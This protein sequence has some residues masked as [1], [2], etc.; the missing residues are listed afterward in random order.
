MTKPRLHGRTEIDLGNVLEARRHI[1][2]LAILQLLA[3]RPFALSNQMALGR[4]E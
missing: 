3:R 1:L 2:R 4:G